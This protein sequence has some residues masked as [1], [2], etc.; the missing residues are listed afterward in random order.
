MDN[1]APSVGNYLNLWWGVP[2]AIW[3]L[4]ATEGVKRTK[5]VPC[6]YAPLL[7]ICFGVLGGALWAM[8]GPP[9]EPGE[10]VL[11][12]CTPGTT[13]SLA[14]EIAYGTRAAFLAAGL[15][16]AGSH[17]LEEILRRLRSNGS[18]AAA[19]HS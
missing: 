6:R 9:P 2:S 11:A 18:G 13:R 8:F 19:G 14:S 10:P 12:R 17:A 4:G 7:C 15:F 1:L 16:T 5:L 3:I